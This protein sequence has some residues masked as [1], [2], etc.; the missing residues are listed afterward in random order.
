M[1]ALTLVFVIFGL[2]FT[3]VLFIGFFWVMSQAHKDRAA[4]REIALRFYPDGQGN[5]PQDHYLLQQG[6]Y[7]APGNHRDQVAPTYL[8][9][10][11]RSEVLPIL[12]QRQ[13]PALSVYGSEVKPEVETASRP[14]L[15]QSQAEVTALLIECKERG[16]SK[17]E[18]L[19]K[20]GITGGRSFAKYAKVFDTLP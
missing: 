2:A 14:Q 10:P 12:P 18:A 7:L 4:K 20:L 17:T 3:L 9:Q 6:I 13:A 5:Y 11:V 15:P 16:M 19:A 8:I 1:L